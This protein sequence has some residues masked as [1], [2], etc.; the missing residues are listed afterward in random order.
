MGPL[1]AEQSPLEELKLLGLTHIL[2]LGCAS[3]PK[4]HPDDLCYL[5]I[6]VRD[7]SDSD[8]L[9]YLRDHD[10][11]GFIERGRTAGGVLVHCVAGISRSAT[12]VITYMMCTQRI[13]YKE[14]LAAV[15]A[16]RVRISPNPGFMDQLKVLEVECDYGINKY[17]KAPSAPSLSRAE[18]E[19]R[20]R[21]CRAQRNGAAASVGVVAPVGPYKAKRVRPMFPP[22]EGPVN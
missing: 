19:A 8:L 4:T 22:D 12:A 6:D 15:I 3:K 11:N 21:E 14:S 20:S 7:A 9:S 1:E 16:K 13:G 2:R 10:T 5:E 18:Q 17:V